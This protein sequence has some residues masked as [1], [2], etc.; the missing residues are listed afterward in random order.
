MRNFIFKCPNTGYNVQY[1]MEETDSQAQRPYVMVNCIAC[2][3]VHWVRR[4]ERSD[5]PS[6]TKA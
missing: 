4:P 3:G 2:G 5:S 1:H 6:D